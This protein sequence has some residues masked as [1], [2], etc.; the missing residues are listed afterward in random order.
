M[1]ITG[2]TV[3]RRYIRN[4]DNNLNNKN[5]SENKISS[6]RKYNRASESPIE[7]AKALKVRKSI[8]QLEDYQSNLDTAK[9]I[10][11]AAESSLMNI[12][13]LIQTTYEKL[14]YG[15]NGTQNDDEDEIL[16]Q[17][18]ETFADEMQ[19]LM[20]VVVADRRIFG[21]TNNSDMAFEIKETNTGKQVYYN[22]KSI[23]NFQDPTSFPYSGTSYTDIGIGM[24]TDDTGRI[25]PQSALPV[26]F[27]GA[28]V[29]GCGLASSTIMVD[30]E[31]M[32][33]AET[34]SLDVWLDGTK[35][36]VS[37]DGGADADES[38]ANI[39]DAINLAFGSGRVSVSSSSGIISSNSLGG[40]GLSVENTAPMD[41]SDPNYVAYDTLGVQTIPT[42]YSSN[43]IQLTLDAA[44]ALRGHDKLEAAK[45]ADALFAAQ[46]NLTLSIANIGNKE[47][48]IDFNTDRITNNIY[49]LYEQQNNLE[50]TDLGTEITNWKVLEAV[51]NA[52]LQMSATVVPMSIF[53]FM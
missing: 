15:A 30:L 38:A 14:I 23:N 34:Y 8:S 3:V 17:T 53:N 7:A 16:A 19:Q 33:P 52:T 45:Y 10:Y 13:T 36:T 31:N 41:I 20:N 6:N 50:G 39:E 27:N 44:A 9:S 21:G 43:I 47:E 26:T 12:S 18:I 5:I 4:L 42:G 51:Y 37:F 46:T 32:S 22:G 29:L 1:R 2:S 25:D 28:E 40:S 48:F 49:T 24:R 11:E 35:S